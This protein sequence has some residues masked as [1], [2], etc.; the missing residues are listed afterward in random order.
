VTKSV[1]LVGPVDPE[2]VSQLKLA[3]GA[4]VTLWQRTDASEVSWPT[5]QVIELVKKTDG[6][7]LLVILGATGL[8]A[9]P[10]TH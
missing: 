2:V 1:I 3:T 6:E 5:E 8:T 10:V 9:I 4:H 7:Q